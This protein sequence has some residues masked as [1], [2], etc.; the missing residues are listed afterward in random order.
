M[1][2]RTGQALQLKVHRRAPEEEEAGSTW[3]SGAF[4][5]GPGPSGEKIKLFRDN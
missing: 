1:K 4:S 5:S 3:T 2:G